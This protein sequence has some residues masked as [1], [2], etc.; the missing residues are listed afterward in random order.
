MFHEKTLQFGKM[1]DFSHTHTQTHAPTH[2]HTYTHTVIPASV[3][4]AARGLMRFVLVTIHDSSQGT[5]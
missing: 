4:H 5:S 1:G 2:T 3:T